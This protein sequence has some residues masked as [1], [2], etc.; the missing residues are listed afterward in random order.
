MEFLKKNAKDFNPSNRSL[1]LKYY[2]SIADLTAEVH[3]NWSCAF[4]PLSFS[5]HE[6]IR[7][8]DLGIYEFLV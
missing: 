2:V 5:A 8:Q 7:K 4:P 1:E 3:E 6:E